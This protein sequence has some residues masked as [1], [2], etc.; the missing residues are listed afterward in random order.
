MTTTA[1]VN[2]ITFT[3]SGN[4]EYEATTDTTSFNIIGQKSPTLFQYYNFK[5]TTLGN[6]VKISAKLLSEGQP[7]KYQDVTV[8]V[9]GED[10]SARTSSTGYFVLDYMTTTSGI[11]NVTFTYNGNTEYD[12]VTNTTTFNVI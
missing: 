4:N 8:T 5:D 10:F 12:G 6:S 7:V 2:N 1:G 9:N 11:N 3:Y